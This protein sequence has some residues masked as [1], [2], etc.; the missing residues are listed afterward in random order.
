MDVL[1][2]RV[3]VRADELFDLIHPVNPTGHE[4]P[5][6][7]ATRRYALKARLRPADRCQQCPRT[8][9]RLAEIA[10]RARVWLEES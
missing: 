1:E 10:C 4:L 9:S 7:E 6:A 3:E 8:G 2:G 5:A